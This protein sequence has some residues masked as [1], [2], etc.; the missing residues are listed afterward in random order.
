MALIQNKK[1]TLNYEIREKFE[2]GIELFGFEVKAL[3]NK[4]GS[5]EGAHVTVR[6]GE[7]YL[8][9][10]H[11]PPYQTA[12]APESYD[13]QRARRLL[14]TTKELGHLAGFEKQ[15]GLTIVPLSLYNRGRFLKL[16]IG[17]ARGKKKFDKRETLKKRTAKR[18]IERTLKTQ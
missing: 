12:N 7:A 18:E 14:L 1:V 2:A 15:K 9:G 16:S 8:M 6:G 11:I 5:L 13:T 4:Q 10:A 17:V 3:R